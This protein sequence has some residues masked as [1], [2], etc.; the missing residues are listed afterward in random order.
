MKKLLDVAGP[1]LPYQ[2]DHTAQLYQADFTAAEPDKFEV[3]DKIKCHICDKD[4]ELKVMR[5]HVGKHILQACC[6]KENAKGVENVSHTVFKFFI[7]L[8][9]ANSWE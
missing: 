4:I 2:L 5:K 1:E 9:I 8:N 3:N 6:Y 7:L